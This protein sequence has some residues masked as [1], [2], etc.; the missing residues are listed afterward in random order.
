MYWE[1]D[2]DAIIYCVHR[3]GEEE[4]RGDCSRDSGNLHHPHHHII[5]LITIFSSPGL[6]VSSV[7]VVH[8]AMSSRVGRVS[9]DIVRYLLQV[10][11]INSY[12]LY[13]I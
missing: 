1:T 5:H 8:A 13:F 7:V 2:I 11:K 10:H 9:R 3:R 12:Q 4:E 6:S